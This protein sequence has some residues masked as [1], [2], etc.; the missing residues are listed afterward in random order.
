MHLLF[1][2]ETVKI[3]G[4]I[5]YKSYIILEIRVRKPNQPRSNN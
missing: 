4:L 2:V 5:D 3:I 1:I